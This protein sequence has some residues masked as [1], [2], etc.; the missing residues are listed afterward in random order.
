MVVAPMFAPLIGGLLDT[1]FGWESIFVFLGDSMPLVLVWANARPCRKRAPCSGETSNV[2]H[3][4]RAAAAQLRPSTATCCAAR[5]APR[6]SS[7]SSA[8]ARMSS[9]SH[10]GPHLGRIWPVVRDHLVRLHGRQFHCVA[11][12]A[13]ARACASMILGGLALQ[14]FGVLGQIVGFALFPA[15]ARRRC[16]SRRLSSR[17]ATACCCRTRSPALS[18]CVPQAAGAASGITGFTQMAIGAAAAQAIS[19]IAGAC[20]RRRCRSRRGHDRAVVSGDDR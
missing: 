6:S 4:W 14:V 7:S 2:W 3:D 11:A 20:D 17:W 8:A 19:M 13:A 15:A 9:S 1:A 5:S 10:D 18:V 16:S 12:V